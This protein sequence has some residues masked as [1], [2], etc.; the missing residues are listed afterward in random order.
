MEDWV[1]WLVFVLMVGL[2]LFCLLNL[3]RMYRKMAQRQR[4]QEEKM[5]PESFAVTLPRSMS[6]LFGIMAL[7]GF[8]MTL[9]GFL[10]S[11]PETLWEEDIFTILIFG[12]FLLGGLVLLIGSL[13]FRIA[14]EKGMFRI[15]RWFGR[16]KII[17]AEEITGLQFLNPYMN[18]YLNVIYFSVLSEGKQ[19]CRFSNLYRG[20]GLMVGKAA[21]I[22]AARGI[23]PDIA[24]DM[25]LPH[26]KRNLLL[27][28][29]ARAERLAAAGEGSASPV[30]IANEWVYD[31]YP[32]IFRVLMVS[33]TDV[34]RLEY[35][36]RSLNE[37]FARVSA[38]GDAYEAVIWENAGWQHPFWECQ[39]GIA[40][41]LLQE[42]DH[43]IGLSAGC[44]TA[45]INAK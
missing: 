23:Y 45:E 33:V 41:E 43:Q 16:E 32:G 30:E 39:R 4:K 15:R 38:G 27:L 18:A 21:E 3:K 11:D 14:Y 8:V 24:D 28:L 5:N 9:L 25:P 29:R 19:I 22:L 2:T 6:V 13:H 26:A 12:V 34:R 37:G 7:F 10:L 42:I 17:P 31:R 20:C 36:I 1:N 40:R 35:L 44:P